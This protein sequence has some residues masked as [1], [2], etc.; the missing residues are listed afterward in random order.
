V[1][2]AGVVIPAI[3]LAPEWPDATLPIVVKVGTNWRND[4]AP[5]GPSV[6]LARS[7][8]RVVLACLRGMGDS[9]PERKPSEAESPLGHNVKEAFLSLHIARPLL[10]QRVADLLCLLESL[11]V[12]EGSTWTGGFD[13]EGTGPAGLVVLHAAALDQRG[14]I[15]RITVDRSLVSWA[16]VV[17]RGIS[18]DQI[19]SVIPGVLQYYDL[20]EL[21]ARLEPRPL[22]IRRAVD[23][24]GRLVTQAELEASYA[25]CR[26]TYGGGGSLVLQAGP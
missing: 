17:Q 16:D 12:E 1:P 3:E 23:T 25:A 6:A 4:L 5:D 13:L 26:L 11:E 20:P 9:A 15:R 22:T 10:G 14:L 24:L 8:R 19:A 21:A 2:E 18:R 7:G